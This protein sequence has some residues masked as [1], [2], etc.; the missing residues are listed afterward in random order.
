MNEKQWV[1]GLESHRLEEE[2][3]R[4]GFVV[5][6]AVGLLHSRDGPYDD[7]VSIQARLLWSQKYQVEVPTTLRVAEVEEEE[8]QHQNR[9]DRQ[10]FLWVS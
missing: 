9:D 5:V 10:Q 2:E 1:S 6:E 8:L 7:K 4:A 3:V